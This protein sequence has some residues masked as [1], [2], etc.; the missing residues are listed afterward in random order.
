MHAFYKREFFINGDETKENQQSR[1]AGEFNERVK[2][3]ELKAEG[4]PIIRPL[5]I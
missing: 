3:G 5:G 4:S 1:R 2:K